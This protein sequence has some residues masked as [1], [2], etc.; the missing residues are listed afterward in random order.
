M[1]FI[2]PGLFLH[3]EATTQLHNNDYISDVYTVCM[4]I[5]QYTLHT[6]STLYANGVKFF[7]KL[8]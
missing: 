2:Q 3:D 7:Y 5:Q 8:N 6:L 4:A 1:V